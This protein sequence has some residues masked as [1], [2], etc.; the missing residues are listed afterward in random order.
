MFMPE[1]LVELGMMRSQAKAEPP[2]FSLESGGEPAEEAVKR[3]VLTERPENLQERED[4]S[5]YKNSKIY[6]PQTLQEEILQ[7]YHDNKLLGQFGFEKTL[8]LLS[9]TPPPLG[10][11]EWERTGVG[12]EKKLAK[13]KGDYKNMQI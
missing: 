13:P 1:Q 6:V 2:L 8:H 7:Q 11:L 5:F 3:E 4:G 12:G 9:W 10:G